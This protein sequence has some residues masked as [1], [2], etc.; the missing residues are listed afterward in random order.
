MNKNLLLTGDTIGVIAP[1][2]PI[3][4]IKKEI[5]AGILALEQMGFKV[6]RGKHLESHF[7]YSAGK[8]EEAC[9]GFA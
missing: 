6:K 8:P 4:N 7:Y 1:S 9:F 3:Y 2:R 5:E